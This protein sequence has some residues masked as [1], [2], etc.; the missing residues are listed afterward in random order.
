MSTAH[1]GTESGTAN[2]T[3]GGSRT[4]GTP[5][6]KGR[7][8]AV[9]LYLGNQARQVLLSGHQGLDRSTILLLAIEHAANTV[10]KDHPRIE[11]AGIFTGSA[12]QPNAR[13]VG[14]TDP[15]RLHV[16]MRTEHARILGDLVA[17]TRLSMS[18]FVEECLLRWD[19]DRRPLSSANGGSRRE[20]DGPLPKM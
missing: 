7:T 9:E 8:R 2:E 13:R 19:R 20:M 10:A 14:L 11:F 17:G 18:G 16:S 1:P 15:K 3:L 5:Y 12:C 4:P 6:R